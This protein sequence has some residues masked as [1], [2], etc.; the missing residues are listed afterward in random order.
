VADPVHC[1]KHAQKCA[2]LAQR[3]RSAQEKRALL[4]LAQTWSRLAAQ[5]EAYEDI[6]CNLVELAPGDDEKSHPQ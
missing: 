1:R 5:T 2:L 3:A 6:L 4:K